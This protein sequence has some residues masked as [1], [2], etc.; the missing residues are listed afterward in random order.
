M[1]GFSAMRYL[2]SILQRVYHDTGKKM[3]DQENV[4]PHSPYPGLW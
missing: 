2:F 3:G 4:L 1:D